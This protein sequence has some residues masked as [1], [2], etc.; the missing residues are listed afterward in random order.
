[1]HL[2]LVESS[3][4]ATIV[5]DHINALG[6]SSSYQCSFTAGR[7]FD[8]E[9]NNH[10]NWSA[11]NGET[12]AYLERMIQRC[13]M[14][15]AMTDADEQG[16][17]IA[18][19]IAVIADRYNKETKKADL[20]ELTSIGINRALNT[21]RELDI[22]II[23]K[24]HSER[25]VHLKV[26]QMTI[27]HGFNVSSIHELMV[28]EYLAT[29]DL[30]NVLQEQDH[31]TTKYFLSRNTENFNVKELPLKPPS[32]FDVYTNALIDRSVDLVELEGE[33]QC[34]YENGL[35]SYARTPSNEWL[36]EA[37]DHIDSLADAN[38]YTSDSK[39]LESHTS[40][41]VPHS[42][43]YIVKP[44]ASALNLKSLALVSEWSL[45]IACPNGLRAFSSDVDSP[46]L[47]LKHNMKT[48]RSRAHPQ[49]QVLTALRDIDLFK[50]STSAKI[51]HKIAT[52]YFNGDH[53]IK[54]RLDKSRFCT[55]AIFPEL[56][57]YVE[58]R[59]NPLN[60]LINSEI[61][62]SNL[63]V[64]HS[65]AERTFVELTQKGR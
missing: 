26:G 53:L 35:L 25:L 60:V 64:N 50:P 14:V 63:E 32:T 34:L 41:N 12:L 43:L 23:Q 29:N 58:K 16:E 30:I 17:Y 1:M 54:P 6:L 28:T 8:F 52:R 45:S 4:K 3:K 62:S 42:A 57:K 2:V 31:S 61:T 44:N 40:V 59:T 22:P 46:I 27:E 7:I 13:E 47:N 33:L 36:P 48:Q 11:R 37:V 65:I 24:T 21:L 51:S 5:N 49:L 56:T 9:L 38:G 15:I 19:Q 10:F 20:V 55:K 18:Y 39:F